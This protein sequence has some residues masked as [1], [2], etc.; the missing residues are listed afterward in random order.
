MA[1][2]K[3]SYAAKFDVG[4]SS[5]LLFSSGLITTFKAAAISLAILL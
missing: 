3:K 4:I 2:I 5:I 1:R